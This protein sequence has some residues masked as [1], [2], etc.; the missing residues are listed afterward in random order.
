MYVGK[1]SGVMSVCMSVRIA[2]LG[3]EICRCYVG[4]YV[5]V[6]LVSMSVS[7]AVLCQYIYW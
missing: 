5:A 3:G 2:V 7:I 6:M 4:K 1:Y